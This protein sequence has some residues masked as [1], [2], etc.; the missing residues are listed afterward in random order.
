M[1]QYVHFVTVHLGLLWG[2]WGVA[3]QFRRDEVLP[4][5]E[6]ERG[7]IPAAGFTSKMCPDKKYVSMIF[8]DLFQ[9][10]R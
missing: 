7:G 10:N 2:E 5:V 9:V 1:Y 8:G 4:S 6:I 3:T